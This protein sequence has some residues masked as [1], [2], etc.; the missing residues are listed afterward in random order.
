LST[1]PRKQ[2]DTDG[3]LICGNGSA[4]GNREKKLGNSVPFVRFSFHADLAGKKLAKT[5]KDFHCGKKPNIL[6]SSL[7]IWKLYENTHFFPR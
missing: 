1:S 3:L 2:Q 7:W 6:L 4:Y 5:G